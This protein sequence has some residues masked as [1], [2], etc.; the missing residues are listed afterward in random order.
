[1]SQQEQ[2]ARSGPNQRPTGIPSYASQ[3][4]ALSVSQ[5]L[6]NDVLVDLQAKV[7]NETVAQFPGE[8]SEDIY[9]GNEISSKFHRNCSILNFLIFNL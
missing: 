6:V 9:L 8:S 4:E 7:I 5:N 2:Q 3:M 1:M